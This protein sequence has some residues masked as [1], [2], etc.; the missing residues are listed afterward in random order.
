MTNAISF[1]LSGKIGHFLRAEGGVSALSYPVP[2]RTVLLGIVGAVL[3]LEKDLP[4]L[5]IEPAQF[6]VS[7]TAPL[8]HWHKAKLR[9][10]PPAAL[11]FTIK[12]SQKQDGNTKAEQGTLIAQEWLVNPCYDIWAILPE[13][14]HTELEERI[15]ERRWHFQPYL[16]LSEMPA[17]IE[18]LNSEPVIKLEHGIYPV[19][20]IIR[21]EDAEIDFMN[22]YE[23]QF[24]IQLFRMPCKVTANRVFNHASYLF[25]TQ[26]RPLMVKT[27]KAYR[28]GERFVMFL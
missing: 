20:S 12:K 28:I 8:T 16:G 19:S 27:S 13:P 23:N 26:A 7:G 2:S 9:K 21:Q 15:R 4:Q 6:A 24:A 3:G 10:D 1:R 25:E 18:F 11:S 17:E 22:I 14:F 5:L